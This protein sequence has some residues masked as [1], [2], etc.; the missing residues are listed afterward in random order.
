MAVAKEIEHQEAETILQKYQLDLEKLKQQVNSNKGVFI[1]QNQ[2]LEFNQIIQDMNDQ[3]TDLEEAHMNLRTQ[4]RLAQD[5]LDS[6][7]AKAEHA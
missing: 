6:A 3:K 4:Y 1:S 7:E 5:K 2:V